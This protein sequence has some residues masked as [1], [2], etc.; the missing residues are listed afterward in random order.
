MDGVEI[1]RVTF[2]FVALAISICYRVLDLRLYR[3][4]DDG[5]VGAQMAVCALD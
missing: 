1:G 4:A 5:G 3:K 2:N